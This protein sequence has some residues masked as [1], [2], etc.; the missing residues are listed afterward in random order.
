MWSMFNVLQFLVFIGEW[1][2]NV[3]PFVETLL[4]QLKKLAL[5]EFIDTKPIKDEIQNAIIP[6]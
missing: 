2:I 1:K 5:F 3:D 4:E 6:S